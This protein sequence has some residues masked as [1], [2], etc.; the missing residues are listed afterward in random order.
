MQFRLRESVTPEETF[1][2]NL[3]LIDRVIRSICRRNCV[4]EDEAE[5]FES[6]A[7]LKLIDNDYAVLRRFQGRSTL[8]TYLTTVLHNLFR[9]YRIGKW[10]KW[11]PSAVAKRKGAVAAQLETLLM[12]DG[13]SLH[14]AIEMLRTN[15]EV[16]ATVEELEAIAA[17]LP[18]RVSRKMDGEASIERM[19]IEGHVEERVIESERSELAARTEATLAEALA[20]LPAE[21]RLMLRMRYQDGFTIASIATALGLEQRPLYRRFERSLVTLRQELEARGLGLDEVRELFGWDRLE[22]E[23]RYQNEEMEKPPAASV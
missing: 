19:V 8:K 21:D 16:E 13:Y 23:I 11:R 12:R 4:L 2:Y 20:T 22:L 14:E 1:T 6:W 17:E 3:E 9:D 10:G 7:R 15:F 5:D 18:P